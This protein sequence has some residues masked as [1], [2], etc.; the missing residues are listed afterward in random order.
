MTLT[1][2]IYWPELLYVVYVLNEFIESYERSTKRPMHTWDESQ[3]IVRLF[4]SKVLQLAGETM[5]EK[6][7]VSFKKWTDG[8]S[9]FSYK[10]YADLYTQFVDYLNLQWIEMD[11][12]ERPKKLHLIAKRLNQHST[13]YEKLKRHINAAAEAEGVY[14]SEIAYGDYDTIAVVW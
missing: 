1:F 10:F 11:P 2:E 7:Y 3:A 9:L 4:Q 14:P 8:T 12:P 5:P 13:E 6:S